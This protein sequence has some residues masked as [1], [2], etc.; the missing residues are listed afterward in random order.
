[1]QTADQLAKRLRGRAAR[2][3]LTWQEGDR[4][5]LLEKLSQVL[6]ASS[7]RAAP[8][9]S[10]SSGMPALLIWE[11]VP[12]GMLFATSQPPQRLTFY[13]AVHLR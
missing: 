9:L 12:I 1:M 10:R 11:H 5:L 8:G 2:L 3:G 7:Q 4:C 6:P 13:K